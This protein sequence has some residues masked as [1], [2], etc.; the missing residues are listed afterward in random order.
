[1]LGPADLRTCQLLSSD[2]PVF[3]KKDLLGYREDQYGELM[4]A[5]IKT[6]AQRKELEAQQKALDGTLNIWVDE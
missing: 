4:T 6:E 2:A 5:I 3:D 1:M